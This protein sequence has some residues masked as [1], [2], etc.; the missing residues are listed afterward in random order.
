[1]IIKVNF[2]L[3]WT[4]NSSYLIKIYNKIYNKKN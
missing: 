3:I 4:A 1:M 2:I